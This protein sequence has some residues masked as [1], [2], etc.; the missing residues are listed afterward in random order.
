MRQ[1]STRDK[2]TVT[3][4]NNYRLLYGNYFALRFGCTCENLYLNGMTPYYIY[5]DIVNR[6]RH[7]RYDPC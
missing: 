3:E 7:I 4:I 5:N 6:A 1:L 2:L